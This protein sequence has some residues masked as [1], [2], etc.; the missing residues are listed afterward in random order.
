MPGARHLTAR[1]AGSS[2][3]RFPVFLLFAGSG[4]LIWLSLFL[5]VGYF[6]RDKWKRFGA[7]LNEPRPLVVIGVVLLI[8]ACLFWDWR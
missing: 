3:V 2:K 1:V 4:A 7:G 8:A 5:T 6:L